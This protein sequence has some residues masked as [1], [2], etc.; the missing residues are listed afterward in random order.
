MVH[1]RKR[2]ADIPNWANQ[3][4]YGPSPHG[5]GAH[6]EFPDIGRTG[7]QRKMMGMKG[8]DR[9][10][11][12]GADGGG[13]DDDERDRRGSTATIDDPLAYVRPVLKKEP[14]ERTDEEIQILVGYFDQFQFS[15]FL[16]FCFFV[17]FFLLGGV[18][19]CLCVFMCVYMR[20]F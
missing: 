11:I 5:P 15:F 16:V 18:Y 7:S 2:S 1:R 17:F 14:G 19:V 12:G 9:S 3:A 13:D 4:S 10:L 20:C 8:S 6:E